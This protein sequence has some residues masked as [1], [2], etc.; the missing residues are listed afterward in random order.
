MA[1]LHVVE[2]GD[3]LTS[4]A[5]R[6][7]FK[8]F[9]PIYSDSANADLRR[10]RPHPNLI[11]AGD[12]VVIPDAARKTVTLATGRRHKIVVKTL[13]RQLKLKLELPDNQKIDGE[14][15]ELRLGEADPPA[16]VIAG[17][18]KSGNMIEADLPCSVT[19]AMLVLTRV[20]ISL[21]LAVGHL[22]PHRAEAKGRP[23]AEGVQG[24]LRNLG[25]WS[26][27][28]DGT[29]D[30]SLTDALKA[31]QYERMRRADPTGYPDDETCDALVQA[32]GC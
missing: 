1:Q 31:F 16:Q 15:Y 5:W 7:G 19:K 25:Y 20:G 11:A 6:Y 10:L 23:L 32:H 13:H 12:Q 3:C 30:E 14:P 21:P 2:K 26:G 28:P 27:E 18:V 8:S 9:D 17:A 4:I 29:V 22:E 24:R